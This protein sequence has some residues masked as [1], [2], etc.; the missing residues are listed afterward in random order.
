MLGVLTDINGASGSLPAW[1]FRHLFAV[2]GS[3]CAMAFSLPRTI[4]PSGERRGARRRAK[5]PLKPFRRRHSTQRETAC[6]SSSSS[7]SSQAAK[8][9]TH[10][11]RKAS[12]ASQASLQSVHPSSSL[13]TH[14]GTHTPAAPRSTTR[15]NAPDVPTALLQPDSPSTSLLAF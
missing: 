8:S 5:W 1:R 9:R 6:T 10:Q 2:C 13:S 7:S 3:S 4:T 11:P 15:L 14:A 12:Q